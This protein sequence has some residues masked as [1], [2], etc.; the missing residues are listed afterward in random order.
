MDVAQVHEVARGRLGTLY[1]VDVHQVRLDTADLLQEDE[2]DVPP[3]HVEDVGEIGFVVQD[4]RQ[5]DPVHVPEREQANDPLLG[6]EIAFAGRDEE[7]VAPLAQVALRAGH[8]LAEIGIG[9]L[10]LDEGDAT[11]TLGVEASACAGTGAVAQP[12]HRLEHLLPRPLRLGRR[13]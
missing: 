4:R 7:D 12:P 3:L 10:A 13:T 6:P 11:G 9:D 5:Q 2:T 8:D 1:V